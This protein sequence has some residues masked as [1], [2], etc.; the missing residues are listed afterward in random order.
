VGSKNNL[1]VTPFLS[2]VLIILKGQINNSETEI[3]EI[4]DLVKTEPGLSGCLIKLSNSVLF[5]GRRDEILN[6]NLD[7]MRLG[8]KKVLDMAYI[9]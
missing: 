2:D 8:L 9:L 6:L 1:N 7:I 5:G 4:S 3:Q